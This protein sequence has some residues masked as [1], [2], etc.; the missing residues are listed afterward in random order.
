M[1]IGN[2]Q[3]QVGVNLATVDDIPTKTSDLTNDSNFI[4][5]YTETDPVYTADKPNIALKTD[6][7]N[8]A[9]NSTVS[10]LQTNLSELQTEVSN[11]VSSVNGYTPNSNGAVEILS[12]TTSKS[13]LMSSSDKTMLNEI[14]SYYK[15][16]LYQISVTLSNGNITLNKGVAIY[17]ASV[18]SNTTFSITNNTNIN[19][20]IAVITFELWVT[21][22]AAATLTFPDSVQ[23]L[24]TPDF[25]KSGT[26]VIV[27][28]SIENSGTTVTK[29]LA[30]LAYEV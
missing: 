29:W 2:P 11:K 26:F 19:L 28:R 15:P 30:N 25:N 3:N 12:A 8:K 22:T 18:S 27:F 17:K 6:L 14:G 9:D 10:T 5:S 23:W 20:D 1:K 21:K 24:V 4:S 13:G 7:N 16:Q